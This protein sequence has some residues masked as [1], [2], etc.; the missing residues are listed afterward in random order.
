[1]QAA[2]VLTQIERAT[3]K[4]QGIKVL[5]KTISKPIDCSTL[6]FFN[7]DMCVFLVMQWTEEEEEAFKKK[8]VDAYEREANPY[9]S[10]ARLWDD[11]V[12]DPSDTRKV[13][14]L[15]LSA[16]SNR[17]LEDTRFGVFRM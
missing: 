15:C 11:G 4:R 8:T 12:I 3:K 6:L 16:A 17:P 7:I 10:T 1:M 5:N 2:G 9:F 13:L 14:G